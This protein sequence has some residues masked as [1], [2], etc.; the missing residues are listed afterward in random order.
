MGGQKD[1]H[2][3]LL[4]VSAVHERSSNCRIVCASDWIEDRTTSM[5]TLPVLYR[6]SPDSFLSS[7]IVG[8][9][10]A[11]N[12][13]YK[14]MFCFLSSTS[15]NRDRWIICI[16][17]TVLS[18]WKWCEK[19]WNSECNVPDWILSKQPSIPHAHFPHEWVSSLVYRRKRRRA[20]RRKT[21][22]FSHSMRWYSFCRSL[23]SRS[24]TDKIR[25]HSSS[26]STDKTDVRDVTDLNSIDEPD[27]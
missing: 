10:S 11:S 16:H 23:K 15:N 20:D 18:G 9:T 27:R 21:V 4:H 3:V 17:C 1:T 25:L 2:R 19:V 13:F 8:P 7:R 14:P 5:L 22:S 24:T 12:R 6:T 26:F